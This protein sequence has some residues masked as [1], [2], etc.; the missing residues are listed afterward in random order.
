MRYRLTPTP[1]LMILAALLA[2]GVALAQVAEF[3]PE[4]IKVGDRLGDVKK[5]L[6]GYGIKNYDAYLI[7]EPAAQIRPEDPPLPVLQPP[8]PPDRGPAG[9][10]PDMG[11]SSRLSPYK[12]IMITPDGKETPLSVGNIT[13]L[14]GEKLKSDL[15]LWASYVFTPIPDPGPNGEYEE[16]LY[17]VNDTYAFSLLVQGHGDSSMVSD[18]VVISLEPMMRKWDP[19]LKVYTTLKK[20]AQ[21][22]NRRTT[23]IAK[24]LYL[25]T[26]K[27]TISLGSSF[28]DILMQYGWPKYFFPFSSQT[29]PPKN[30]D[31][32]KPKELY[33]TP[34]A[35]L[36]SATPGSTTLADYPLPF[37]RFAAGE[38]TRK[39]TDGVTE[40]IDAGF[41]RNCYISYENADPRESTVLTLVDYTVVRIHKGMGASDPPYR[42][43]CLGG[44][45]PAGP[46]PMAPFT[47]TIQP[48]PKYMPTFKI[49]HEIVQP[50]HYYMGTA[51]FSLPANDQDPY[52]FEATAPGYKRSNT[53]YVQVLT[54][55]PP[56]P[57]DAGLAPVGDAP[58]LGVQPAP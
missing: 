34:I 46:L 48:V 28:Y 49:N 12:T 40:K 3:P 1:L 9:G 31:P 58:A 38:F 53:I 19:R 33:Q 7:L 51:T 41:T 23:G 55:P 20:R 18:I 36:A 37:G 42:P 54:P 30:Y 35:I 22:I 13:P 10:M 6:K 47:V 16:Y 25:G 17:R 32:L 56:P 8:P 14:P 43:L 52:L 21:D 27:K 15:E 45:E 4:A 57:V 5:V 2:T 29:T 50:M 39:F 24:Q 11:L 44:P 26:A